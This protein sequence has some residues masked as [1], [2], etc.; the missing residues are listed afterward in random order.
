MS[1]MGV[2]SDYFDDDPK[3][4]FSVS[5]SVAHSKTFILDLISSC[6]TGGTFSG[7]T[8]SEICNE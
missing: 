1:V 6:V 5:S 7:P 8:L 4:S 3:I 2:R